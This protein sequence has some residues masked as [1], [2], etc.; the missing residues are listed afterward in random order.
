MFLQVIYIHYEQLMVQKDCLGHQ[1][2]IRKVYINSLI[3]KIYEN[4]FFLSQLYTQ[5]FLTYVHPFQKN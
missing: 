2:N 5:F 3:I 1:T 4:C